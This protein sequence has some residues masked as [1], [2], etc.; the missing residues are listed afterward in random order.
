M[1]GR[2]FFEYGVR[3]AGIFGR[4]R[5]AYRESFKVLESEEKKSAEEVRPLVE[6]KLR[7]IKARPGARFAAYEG[8]RSEEI[9]VI[10]GV[11]FRSVSFMVLGDVKLFDGVVG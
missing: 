3:V 8:P 4:N 9:R 5:K 1:A 7:E 10:D 11:S 6:A 2:K